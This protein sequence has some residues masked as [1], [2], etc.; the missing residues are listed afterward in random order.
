MKTH[1]IPKRFST[2]SKLDHLISDGKMLGGGK[3]QDPHEVSTVQ[4]FEIGTR[5]VIGDQAYRYARFHTDVD[6]LTYALVNGNIIPDDGAEVAV[7]GSPAIGDKTLVVLDTHSASNRPIN[8]YQGGYC[9]IYRNPAIAQSALNHDQFRKI[10]A[11]TVGNTVS[12]T[13]TLDYP[14]TCVPVATVDCY[15]SPYSLVCKSG[16]SESGSEMFVGYAHAFHAA[17]GFGWVQTWGPGHGHYTGGATEWP[18]NNGPNDRTVVF[19]VEGGIRT[20]KSSG[21]VV[22]L[23]SQIA[24]YVI[25]CTK[26]N[27]GS[28][29]IYLMIAP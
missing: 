12:I 9:L 29:F 11:S 15:P 5:L 25:P 10:I 17:G 1:Y 7:G 16:H 6:E 8:Y 19:S 23:A 18:G 20:T 22:P 13:L 2:G 24:G 28:C 26:S 21:T 14:L 27:Y 4:N 3:W